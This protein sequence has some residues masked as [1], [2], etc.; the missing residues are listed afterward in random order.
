MSIHNPDDWSRVSH[1]PE[2]FQ[3]VEVTIDGE[4]VTGIYIETD[5]RFLL[6]HP[7]EDYLF[8]VYE[9][10]T[11]DDNIYMFVGPIGLAYIQHIPEDVCLQENAQWN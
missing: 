3:E 2:D 1:K 8:I 6:P 9:V 11:E 10:I 5:N 4:T 7:T